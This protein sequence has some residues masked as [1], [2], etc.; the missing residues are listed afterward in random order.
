MY[1]D[2]GLDTGDILLTEKLTLAPGE[3]GGT[4]HDRLSAL[5]P[6]APSP[7]ATPHPWLSDRGAQISR[8]TG[9][10]GGRE[11]VTQRWTSAADVLWSWPGKQAVAALSALAR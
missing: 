3:T 5:A 1:M 7:A 9:A 11:G 10:I 8:W 6:A 4:L 2:K